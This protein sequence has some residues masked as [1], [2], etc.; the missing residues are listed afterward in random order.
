M[1]ASPKRKLGVSASCIFTDIH[2]NLWNSRGRDPKV[3]ESVTVMY[4]PPKYKDFP[5]TPAEV[6]AMLDEKLDARDITS[7]IVGL[8]VKGYIKIEETKKEGLI[9]DSTDYYLARLKGPDDNLSQFEKMLMG[10]L[11]SDSMP[12]IMV[13]DMKN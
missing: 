5:L 10:N 12:G 11:F 9:F 4:E 2:D 6:G 13:S 7:T 3:R 8:A 1:G